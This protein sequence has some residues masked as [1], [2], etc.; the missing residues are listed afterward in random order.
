MHPFSL[1]HTTAICQ[2]FKNSIPSIN[3][4]LCERHLKRRYDAKLDKLLN[5]LKQ[6][7]VSCQQAKSSIL[8]DIKGCLTGGFYEFVSQMYLTNKI[9][10]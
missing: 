7:A 10:N 5:R 3:G 8:Q 6:N 4:L 9:L 1:I 2:G